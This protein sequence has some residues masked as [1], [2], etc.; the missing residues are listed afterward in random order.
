MPPRKHYF[1]FLTLCEANS[2]LIQRSSAHISRNHMA[3]FEIVALKHAQG[4]TMTISQAMALRH[5]ASSSTLHVRID[6]L[7]EAGMIQVMHKES[8]KRSKYLIPSK[9]GEQYLQLIGE[10]LRV[11]YVIRQTR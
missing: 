8:R 5:M 10:L 9:K 2:A 1:D 11:M 3:L 6:D 7:R 4:Q